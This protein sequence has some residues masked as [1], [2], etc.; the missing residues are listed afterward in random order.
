MVHGN[1]PGCCAKALIREQPCPRFTTIEV[2]AA[3]LLSR[4]TTKFSVSSRHQTCGVG[5]STM[6]LLICQNRGL[7]QVNSAQCAERP[8]LNSLED[9]P[10]VYR[11]ITLTSRHEHARSRLGVG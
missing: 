6:L 9:P 11:N 2:L 10:K 4:N 7:M 3:A 8:P 5:F 1:S